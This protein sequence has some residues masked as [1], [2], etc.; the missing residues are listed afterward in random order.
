MSPC[1]Y[2]L[3]VIGASGKVQ[4][5]LNKD[6]RAPKAPRAHSNLEVGVSQGVYMCHRG[7]TCDGEP[8]TGLKSTSGVVKT[9]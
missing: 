2:Y 7:S 8:K 9:A 6:M 3:S 1:T 4:V 5:A